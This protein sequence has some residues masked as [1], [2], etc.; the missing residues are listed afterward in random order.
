MWWQS[1]LSPKHCQQWFLSNTGYNLSSVPPNQEEKKTCKFFPDTLIN[2]FTPL[3]FV[4][5]DRK[6]GFCVLLILETI[7][8]STGRNRTL[9]VT[10][11]D[12]IHYLGLQGHPVMLGNYIVPDIKYR[13]ALSYLVAGLQK[14]KF[15]QTCNNWSFHG[16]NNKSLKR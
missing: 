12:D 8:G 14:R 4:T 15:L 1:T 2:I 7:L 5:R 11:G 6:A 16:Y 13:H 3:A 9:S 10:P